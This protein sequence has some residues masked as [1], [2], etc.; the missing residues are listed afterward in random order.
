M[1]FSGRFLLDLIYSFFC[2]LDKIFLAS[3]RGVTLKFTLVEG[4]QE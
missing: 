3:C 1:L 2:L 4:R